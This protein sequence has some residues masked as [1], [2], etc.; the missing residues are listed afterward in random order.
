MTF[1]SLPYS[2]YPFPCIWISSGIWAN[3]H[4]YMTVSTAFCGTSGFSYMSGIFKSRQ[5]GDIPLFPAETD[6]ML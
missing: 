3:K 5:Y 2:V 4:A 1:D 6:R